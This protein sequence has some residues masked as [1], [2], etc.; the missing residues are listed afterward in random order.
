MTEN[1]DFNFDFDNFEDAFDFDFDD[2]PKNQEE[3]VLEPVVEQS[4]QNIQKNTNESTLPVDDFYD[5]YDSILNEE[6]SFSETHHHQTKIEQPVQHNVSQETFSLDDAFNEVFPGSN[7]DQ[8]TDSFNTQPS[9]DSQSSIDDLLYS[10]APSTAP[11]PEPV[12]Q[13]KMDDIS[14]LDYNKKIREEAAIEAFNIF[15]GERTNAKSP[16]KR[17][18]SVVK[19]KSDYYVLEHDTTYV[20]DEDENYDLFYEDVLPIDYEEVMANNQNKGTMKKLI[21]LLGFVVLIFIGLFLYIRAR[22]ENEG[23]YY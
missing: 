23:I 20:T 4:Q 7:Q 14:L 15:D 22:M 5:D 13:E 9:S 16:T 11:K 2:T 18:Q 17:A 19:K 6:A 3:I 10:I 1:K 8:V 12:S 21:I